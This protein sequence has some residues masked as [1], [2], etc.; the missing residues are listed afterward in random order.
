[1][2]KIYLGTELKL[3]VN[4]D[5]IGGIHMDSYD[6]KVELFTSPSKIVTVSSDDT[7]NALRQDEDN[8]IIKADTKAIGI[9]KL[10]CRVTAYIPDG[11]FSD[12]KRTEVQLYN[13]S[14]DIIKA[15]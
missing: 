3:N 7:D 14:I 8:Y 11:D 2:S 10:K 9:G 1:M 12:Y 13:P 15:D 4:I 5:P 6:W